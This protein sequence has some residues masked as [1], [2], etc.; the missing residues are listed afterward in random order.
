MSQAQ[1]LEESETLSGDRIATVR[2]KRGEEHLINVDKAICALVNLM[3][4]R[5]NEQ[6]FGWTVGSSWYEDALG[7]LFRSSIAEPESDKGA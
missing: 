7:G 4:D 2:S 5:A 6:R 1:I 3:S